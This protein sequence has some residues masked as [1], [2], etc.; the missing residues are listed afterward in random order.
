[1][2]LPLRAEITPA[3]TTPRA[4]R[5]RVFR[6]PSTRRTAPSSSCDAALGT[7]Y[8]TRAHQLHRTAHPRCDPN[9][10]RRIPSSLYATS[11]SAV[12]GQHILPTS[13]QPLPPPDASQNAL[14]LHRFPVRYKVCAITVTDAPA[15]PRD[16]RYPPP[17][18]APASSDFTPGHGP[19]WQVSAVLPHRASKTPS[20]GSRVWRAANRRRHE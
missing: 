7:T 20:V 14:T 3:R 12:L 8:P 10:P 16:P 15:G 4:L 9:Q 11:A 1:M 2:P 18:A 19:P 6:S 17:H 5:T 13:I